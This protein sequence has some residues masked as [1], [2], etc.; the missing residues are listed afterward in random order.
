M[1]QREPTRC[2]SEALFGGLTVQGLVSA[3]AALRSGGHRALNCW[4]KPKGEPL[5]Q[6]TRM[7][8]AVAS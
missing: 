6:P 4:L 8:R 7:R 3:K 5:K 2:S 1:T